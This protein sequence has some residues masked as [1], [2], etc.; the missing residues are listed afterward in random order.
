MQVHENRNKL[1]MING[2]VI[3]LKKDVYEYQYV[4]KNEFLFFKVIAFLR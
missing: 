1:L 3:T 2:D 4:V